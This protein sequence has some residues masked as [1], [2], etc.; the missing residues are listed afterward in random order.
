ML[1]SN[2]SKRNEEFHAL[3]VSKKSEEQEYS[4]IGRVGK[5][6]E[7]I[8]RPLGFDWQIG[9]GILSSFAAREVIV[10]TLAVVY[11]VG[12]EAAGVVLIG[13]GGADPHFDAVEL[14]INQ[15]IEGAPS[16]VGACG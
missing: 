10:S 6:I 12:E 1:N 14:A 7:P 15:K 8:M 16:G 5:I 13:E 9:I 2:D 4:I 11:G 3:E